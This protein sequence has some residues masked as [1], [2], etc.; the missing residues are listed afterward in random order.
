MGRKRPSDKSKLANSY[1]SKI[2]QVADADV[3]A[4][5]VVGTAIIGG[6]SLSVMLAKLFVAWFKTDERDEGKRERADIEEYLL[7]DARFHDPDKVR[8]II[9]K[10]DFEADVGTVA[11]SMGCCSH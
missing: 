9:Y 1:L 6:V 5:T 11:P 4:C 10:T 2:A 7:E 8:A 3:I